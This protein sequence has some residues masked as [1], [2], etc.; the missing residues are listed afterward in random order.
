[1]CVPIIRLSG[2]ILF[3]VLLASCSPMSARSEQIVLYQIK[4]PKQ[5][6]YF[7]T[8]TAQEQV[9]VLLASFRRLQA[10]DMR[11]LEWLAYSSGDTPEE[12]KLRISRVSN[13][14]DLLTLAMAIEALAYRHICRIDS[15]EAYLLLSEIA[16]RIEE[17]P[18]A[19][20]MVDR[21]IS[22]QTRGACVLD[23]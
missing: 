10:W 12:I 5:Q 8:L 11:L 13:G 17:N 15:E 21:I 7:M 9:D 1:M 3:G 16:D 14:G 18:A 23:D 19:E 4:V 6:G 20:N 22:R 2:L